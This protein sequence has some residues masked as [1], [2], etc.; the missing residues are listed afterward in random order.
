MLTRIP[1]FPI[2]VDVCPN[3]QDDAC[4]PIVATFVVWLGR[5]GR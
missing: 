5:D 4:D 1:S 3:E 2:L